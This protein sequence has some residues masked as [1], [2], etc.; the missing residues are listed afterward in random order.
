LNG[1]DAARIVRKELRSTRILFLTMHA[2]IPLVE[3]AFGAGASGFITKSSGLQEFLSAV[4]TVSR[5]ETFISP[6]LAEKLGSIL[7]TVNP[8]DTAQERVLTTRQRETL[9]LLAEGKTMKETA[10]VM[11]ISPRTAECHKYEIMRKLGGKTT[12]DLI[13]Y[14]VRIKLV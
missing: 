3:D 6:E 13:R 9:Q 4:Q 2:D 14:A 7:T 10:A 5:G 1:I 12:A 11:N 8:P